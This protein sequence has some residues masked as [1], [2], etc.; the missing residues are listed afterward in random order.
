MR[1][2]CGKLDLAALEALAAGSRGHGWVRP[3]A[4][5]AKARCGGP[6]LCLACSRELA[7][8]LASS[9]ERA[10]HD[11]RRGWTA[12]ALDVLERARKLPGLG[13]REAP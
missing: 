5:G 2:I 1:R 9:I 13:P 7:E 6:A 8:A 4:G 3:I 10:V 12:A 11:L